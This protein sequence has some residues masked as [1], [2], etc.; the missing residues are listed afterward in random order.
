MQ[1][2]TFVRGLK[3]DGSLI[4]SAYA[5]NGFIEDS[6]PG[7][8]QSLLKGRPLPSPSD[9]HTLIGGEFLSVDLM[10]P[11]KASSSSDA[12][13]CIAA[14]T[15]ALLPVVNRGMADQWLLEDAEK[16][17]DG[18]LH[19]F[20]SR[21]D[22]TSSWTHVIDGG[23]DSFV[24]IRVR[25]FNRK[26]LWIGVWTRV[27]GGDFA[28]L[29]RDISSMLDT[30]KHDGMVGREAMLAAQAQL[31]LCTLGTVLEAQQTSAQ[32]CQID[33]L[34]LLADQ[35]DDSAPAPDAAG[36][37]ARLGAM[38]KNVAEL[39]FLLSA[40]RRPRIS[41]KELLESWTSP[42]PRSYCSPQSVTTVA[43]GLRDVQ[44]AMSDAYRLLAAV[45]SAEEEATARRFESTIAVVAS[46]LVVPTLVAG[47]Y[48]ANVEFPGKDTREGFWSMLVWMVVGAL[49]VWPALRRTR[50]LAIITAADDTKGVI[51]LIC[52]L[53]G[54]ALVVCGLP[55]V[56]TVSTGL[57]VALFVLGIV[58]WVNAALVT[59][60]SSE[61][62]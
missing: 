12:S 46:I 28:S 1:L 9:M 4:W 20:N 51:A 6:N 59:A 36:P 5:V 30:A 33:M 55:G 52:V 45:I 62:G 40:A 22:R 21:G 49:V 31:Q 41:R 60:D 27:S 50:N 15:E 61:A 37:S 38:A 2:I 32:G 14:W 48:G 19:S 34:G 39:N 54:T 7:G 29:N 56:L 42:N 18:A 17:R 47:V 35:H 3:R 10:L 24:P 53:G 23:G 58:L 57:H 13:T 43:N 44:A 16:W 26:R 8:H 25:S 11:P